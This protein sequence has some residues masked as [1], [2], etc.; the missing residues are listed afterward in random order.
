MKWTSEAQCVVWEAEYTNAQWP[1]CVWQQDS[2]GHKKLRAPHRNL[3]S[4]AGTVRTS[5]RTANFPLFAGLPIQDQ[6]EK[7]NCSPNQSHKTPLASR[8]LPLTF[9]GQQLTI[10]TYLRRSFFQFYKSCPLPCLPLSFSQRQVMLSYSVAIARAEKIAS[11]CS[12]LG[13]FS[14]ILQVNL[15]WIMWDRSYAASHKH[16]QVS[17]VET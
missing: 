2:E 3:C 14:L 5:S 13:G 8:S 12:H 7:A 16:H 9:P 17:G 15:N 6:S 11:V 1:N 4:W 10:R